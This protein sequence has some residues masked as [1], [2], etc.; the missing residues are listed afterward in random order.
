MGELLVK[1]PESDEEFQ[2]MWQLNHEVFAGELGQHPRHPDCRLVD[3]FHH[4]NRYRI[5]WDGSVAARNDLCAFRTSVFSEMRFGQVIASRIRKGRTAEDPP[6]YSQE[7]IPFYHSAGKTCR[8]A[9]AG[10]EITGN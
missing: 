2:A 3:K 5:A 4:K 9:S 8:S 7:G 10:T 1:V 6:V